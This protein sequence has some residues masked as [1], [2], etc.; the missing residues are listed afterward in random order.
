MTK[1]DEVLVLTQPKLIAVKT[2]NTNSNYFV[3]DTSNWD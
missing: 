1:S 3:Y 2:I